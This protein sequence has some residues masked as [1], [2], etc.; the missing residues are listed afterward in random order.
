MK[1]RRF[2]FSRQAALLLNNTCNMTIQTTQHP[3]QAGCGSQV[4][5]GTPQRP[6]L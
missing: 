1:P 6:G 4:V 2:F 3:E 5:P